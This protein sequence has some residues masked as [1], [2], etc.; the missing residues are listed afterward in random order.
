MKNTHV[1]LWMT[2]ILIFWSLDV[3]IHILYVVGQLMKISVSHTL[4]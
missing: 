2:D 1:A 4:S 3:T